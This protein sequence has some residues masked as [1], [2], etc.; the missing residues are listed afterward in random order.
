M[1]NQFPYQTADP[2]YYGQLKEWA[3]E[4][5]KH[6]TDAEHVLWMELKGNKLGHKFLFQ[7]IIGQYI[8]DF[9]CPDAMLVVEVDG[10]YHSEP[11]QMEDDEAR[12][13]WLS[14][15]GYNVIRFTNEEVLQDIDAVIEGIYDQVSRVIIR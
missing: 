12:T 11:R 15:M 13:M 10:G 14:K 7:Y 1:F 8:V 5:R 6:P 9:L 3:K 2:A 4:N